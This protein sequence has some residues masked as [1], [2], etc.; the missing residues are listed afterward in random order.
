[1]RTKYI[2]NNSRLYTDIEHTEHLFVNII[3]CED[4]TYALYDQ[5]LCARVCM[6]PACLLPGNEEEECVRARPCVYRLGCGEKQS[7]RWH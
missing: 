3:H 4:F 6:W 1:M 5:C 2:N 7:T